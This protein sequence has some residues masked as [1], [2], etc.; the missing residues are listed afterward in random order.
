MEVDLITSPNGTSLGSNFTPTQPM[1]R[2]AKINLIYSAGWL[3]LTVAYFAYYYDNLLSIFTPLLGWALL[4]ACV[5]LAIAAA[6]VGI[7]GNS[8]MPLA[9]A[10]LVITVAI[11]GWLTPAG[12]SF[13]AH[14]KLW[15]EKAHYQSVITRLAAGADDSASDHPIAVD[16]GPPRRVAFSWGGILD[17]W[18]GVVYDPTGEVMKADILDT[19]TWSNRDDPDYA[20]VAGWFGGSLIRAK[21]LEGN[22]YLCWF[23]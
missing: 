17:N 4:L 10:G 9:V 16:P 6:M 11:V 5:P 21:H 3:L 1:N 18:V 8:R 2:S 14:C 19:E 22:W 13:G 23:T 12:K 20:S 15:R 7:K